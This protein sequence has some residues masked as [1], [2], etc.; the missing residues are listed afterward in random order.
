[1]SRK[2]VFLIAILIVFLMPLQNFSDV[3]DENGSG[4][5]SEFIFRN[6]GPFRAGSWIS[7]I[8]VP[9]NPKKEDRFTFYVAARNGGVWKTVNNGTTFFPIFD[10]YEVNSIGSVEVAPSDSSI[11]WVGTGDDSNARSAY[12][13][14]GIYKSTDGGKTFTNMG[15][16]D[17]HHIGKIIIHPKDP[18][19]VYV[20]VMGH[21]FSFNEERGVFKT[22]DGGKN[23]T[24]ILYINERTG[25]ADICINSKDPETL[26]ATSYNMQ[27]YPWH[28][29]AGGEKSRIYRT[30][31]GGKNWKKLEAGLP[32]GKLG[33]IGVDIC[34]SVP[35]TVY[36]VIQ[37]LNPKPDLNKNSE[38]K[39]D[40]F[41]DHSY[42]EL[43]G[44]EVYRSDD[45]GENWRKVSLPG[46]DVSGKAAYSFN[47]INVDPIDPENVYIIAV[48]MLYSKDG[49]KSWPGWNNWQERKL[50]RKNF[51]DVRTFWIDPAD[52]DHM[53]LGSDGGLYSSWDGGKTTFHHYNIPMGEIYDV[54]TDNSEPYN[55]YAGL[56][57]HETWKSPVNGW[58]GSIGLEDWVITGMW[59]GMYTSVDPEDN[60]W[61]YFTTQFGKHHRVDQLRGERFEIT[62]ENIKDRPPYRYT[63][64]TP[65]VLSPHDSK[66]VYT[67]GQM[68]LRS[69]DR[70]ISWKEISPDLTLNDPEKIAGKGHIMYC[71]IT[72]ISES[73]LRKGMIWVGTDDGRVH[74][75]DNNGI[76]WKDRTSNI[77][78]AGGPEQKWVSRI[79]SSSHKPYRAYLVKSGYREDDFRSYIYRTDNLGRTWK[80]ISGD[81]PDSPV[82]VI[83]EDKD[84]RS[85]LFAGTDSG[86]YFTFNGGKNWIRL[87]NNMPPVP[88]RDLLIQEPTGDL[89]VGTYGRGVW[90]TNIA[91]LKELSE[92]IL[93]KSIHLFN[94]KSRPL[95]ISSQRAWW[96]NYHMTGDAHLRTENEKPGLNIYY[97][98]RSDKI[99][100]PELIVSDL[101]GKKLQNIKLKKGKGIHILNWNSTDK[102]PGR[103]NFTLVSAKKKITRSG[104]LKPSILWP[105][106]EI[107]K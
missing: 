79:V 45:N 11:I 64:T 6:L 86:V 12:Y 58:S 16:K 30:V 99:P 20:A 85:L 61:L 57:D 37:N 15:L 88:V 75:T 48:Q 77:V 17:S 42:D 28:F 10:N 81:I 56:Q 91:P 43:I 1:M 102:K 3:T 97:Y 107:H 103:F 80:D 4:L 36:A 66:V 39:F 72:S 22:I 32:A 34:R 27:R 24:K 60:R 105:V 50:F 5:F 47:E 51:G 74:V 44:G 95:M 76:H 94:I 106:K 33:R 38:A 49:G 69:L 55:I 63:W 9:V 90:V 35:D 52:P 7:D 101:S 18:D 67:G 19:I 29:E 104:V 54:E 2:S 53:M 26:F 71:T 70:G 59:D 8:A 100:A 65:I 83:I 13:G 62:P 31:D 23:W 89:V 40:A 84:N 46:I 41:T 92:K 73:P 25:A 78:R 82:S 21:L 96:G 93:K 68:L 87:K 14:N 98:L